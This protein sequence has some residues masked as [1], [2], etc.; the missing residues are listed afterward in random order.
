MLKS[1]AFNNLYILYY[2][3]VEMLCRN[4]F[5]YKMNLKTA[6]SETKFHPC[7]SHVTTVQRTVSKSAAT[8]YHNLL[9][10]MIEN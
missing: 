2:I 7:I 10:L 9:R 6:N 5:I 1:Y 8:N 3:P 4:T